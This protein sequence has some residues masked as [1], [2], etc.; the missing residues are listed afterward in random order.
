M[1]SFLLEILIFE[2]DFEINFVN[3]TSFSFEIGITNLTRRILEMEIRRANSTDANS[4]LS[5]L[6]KLD[7]ETRY[8][9]FQPNERT[10]DLEAIKRMILSSTQGS[11]LLL[12][13]EDKEEIVGYLMAQRPSLNKIKHTAHIVVGIREN[14]RGKGIGQSLFSQLDIWAKENRLSRLE[15]TVICENLSAKSL[16]EK[17]GFE[18]EGIKRQSIFMDGQYFDEYYMAKIYQVKNT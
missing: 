18:V 7:E 5:M 6:L 13:V 10:K 9:L 8:M 3:D 17:N 2:L 4:L 1:P 15:L 12:V 14:Y 16:Y 11:N